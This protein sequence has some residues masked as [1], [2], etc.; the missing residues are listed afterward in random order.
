MKMLE[1]LAEDFPLTQYGAKFVS[2]AKGWAENK[3]HVYQV[4]SQSEQ[5]IRD[6]IRNFTHHATIT[7]MAKRLEAAVAQP[8]AVPEFVRYALERCLVSQEALAVSI[9]E[10]NPDD[11]YA[12]LMV[13]E[14]I[15]MIRRWLSSCDKSESAL[16]AA[17]DD[18]ENAP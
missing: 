9:D 8:R 6:A 12:S 3:L 17:I 11:P 15:D 16:N 10:S 4:A 14:D 7:D 1:D 5:I 13:N 2:I 18:M